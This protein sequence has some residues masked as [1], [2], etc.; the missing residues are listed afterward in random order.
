MQVHELPCSSLSL[1]EVTW[2]YIKFHELACSF[3]SLC[4]L[5][6]FVW[7]ALKN[8]AVLVRMSPWKK[9]KHSTVYLWMESVKTRLWM[10]YQLQLRFCLSRM[11]AGS[12]GD[13]KIV[14][15]YRG[16]VGVNIKIIC[17][18]FTRMFPPLE[19]RRGVNFYQKNFF[20]TLRLLEF[21]HTF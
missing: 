9:K 8:F 4:V 2:A 18:V 3:M 21:S 17:W 7:A 1:H 14:L 13:W 6:F 19:C 5:P 15:S 11:A 10:R 20:M 16:S 12:K